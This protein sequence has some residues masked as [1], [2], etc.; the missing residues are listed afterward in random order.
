MR[1][2]RGM[3][4][5]FTVALIGTGGEADAQSPTKSDVTINQAWARATPKGASVGAAY[6]TIHNG[7]STAD[8]LIGA[9]TDV[10]HSV[11]I[12][13]MRMNGTIMQ[14]REL[15]DGLVIPP[16]KDVI[17]MPSGFHLMLTSLPHPLAAGSDFKITLNFEKS[18]PI[19]ADFHVA[20]MGAMSPDSKA[21][22]PSSMDMG[23]HPM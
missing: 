1:L 19:T 8:R 21:Q 6:M 3:F 18:G 14:M 7:G 9:T 10:A 22:N 5:S 15:P 23:G 16:G 4:L 11:Q 17:L 12:H 20:G 13:E 2:V